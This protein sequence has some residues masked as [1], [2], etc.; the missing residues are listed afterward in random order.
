MNF[1]KKS[2]PGPALV[3]LALALDLV[4]YT[5]KKTVTKQGESAITQVKRVL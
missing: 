1:F 4:R 5:G 3:T 2:H